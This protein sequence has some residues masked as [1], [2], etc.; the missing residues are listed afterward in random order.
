M[1]KELEALEKLEECANGMKDLPKSN[2]IDLAENEAELDLKIMDWVETIKFELFKGRQALTELQ[3]IKGYLA[4]DNG[5]IMCGFSL[6]GKQLCAMP[7]EEYDKMQRAYDELQAIKK[8]EPSEFKI[9]NYKGQYYLQINV[10]DDEATQ[11]QLPL[12]ED[13]IKDVQ[14]AIDKFKQIKSAEPSEA[15]EC[16]EDLIFNFTV[17]EYVDR[18]DKNLATIKQALMSKSNA[19]RLN[20]ILIDREV[21]I[22][23][24][25][26]RNFKDYEDYKQRGSTDVSSTPL[27]QEEFELLKR[28]SGK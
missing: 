26:K 4:F 12:L 9:V 1:D 10:N 19:E 8:A 16:V 23:T 24:F 27:T 22:Q 20:Q 18:Y 13:E 25:R 15:L 17:D 7:L 11:I 28:W 2:W 5:S 3:A 21:N 14:L 6:N